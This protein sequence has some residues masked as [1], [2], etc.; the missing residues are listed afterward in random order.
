MGALETVKYGKLVCN[1]QYG[2][3]TVPVPVILES[4]CVVDP[5]DFWDADQHTGTYFLFRFGYGFAC[6]IG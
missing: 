2:T 4:I 1:L 3:N 5:R 6:G